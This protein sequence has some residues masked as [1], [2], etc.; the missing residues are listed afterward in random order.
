MTVGN[1]VHICD[2]LKITAWTM[3]R[4][5]IRESFDLLVHPAKMVSRGTAPV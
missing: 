5:P 3:A 1:L 2:K 4:H